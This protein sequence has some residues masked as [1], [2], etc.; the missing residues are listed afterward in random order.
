MLLRRLK[1]AGPLLF[2]LSFL[3]VPLAPAIADNTQ[4][5]NFNN[6]NGNNGGWLQSV[7]GSVSQGW[8]WNLVS[9]GTG[10]GGWQAFIEYNAANSGV[11]LTSPC[12]EIQSNKDV[13]VDISHRFD[14]PVSGSNV[15]P[16]ALGQ[17]QFRVDPTGSGTAWGPWQGIP[18]QYFSGTAPP[19]NYPP[20]YGPNDPGESL[21][22]PLISSATTS[23]GA[24][25]VQA[26]SGQTLGFASGDHQPSQ[27]LLD[28]TTFGLANGY[29][30]QLRFVMSTSVLNDT[31]RT[32]NW[33]VNSVQIK[34]ATECVVPEPGSL[35]LAAAGLVAGLGWHARRRD[36]RRSSSAAWK[37]LRATAGCGDDLCRGSPS[38][39]HTR[40]GERPRVQ[41]PG[42]SA[43][44]P[45]QPP[46]FNASTL[47]ELRL[48]GPILSLG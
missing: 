47:E 35:A 45:H 13:Q 30:L 6:T 2:A 21:F 44:T 33:E 15:L 38:T 43:L 9:T 31:S 29:D 24:E 11:Y 25:P 42:R 1:N 18:T 14:F 5:Y 39:P 3:A 7:T 46:L 4:T 20:N 48:H 41:P 10:K 37:P 27:F 26:W 34:G 32:L 19:A 17:I 36:R 28:F 23:N 8:D 12:L 16:N 40:L 22:G